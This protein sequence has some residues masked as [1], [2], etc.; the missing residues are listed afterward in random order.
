[1]QYIFTLMNF[2]INNQEL[3]FRQIQQYTVLTLGIG[4]IFIDQLQLT[5]FQKSACYAGIKIFNSL[6]SNLRSLI[7]RKAQ[8]KVA[9]KTYL[10]TH[11][12]YSVEEFL[13]VKYDSCL[14]YV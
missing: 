9:L 12:F 7:N 3:F 4:A 11:S 2:V 8:F 13:T 5:C 14:L 10:N 1:M 6:P